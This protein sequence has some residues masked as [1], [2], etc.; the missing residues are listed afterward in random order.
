MTVL[1]LHACTLVY[2]SKAEDKIVQ[3]NDECCSTQYNVHSS[4]MPYS[5]GHSELT[6]VSMLQCI[7]SSASWL[8]MVQTR[9]RVPL[10]EVYLLLELLQGLLDEVSH[11][12][13]I[14]PALVPGG[15]DGVRKLLQLWII[16]ETLQGY[17]TASA[18]DKV[19][20]KHKRAKM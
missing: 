9:Q 3:A 8:A 12:G 20:S 15:N 13:D 6:Q 7:Q 10:E 1:T 17:A 19:C 2:P 4:D 16:L 18:A 11:G 5:A 14:A